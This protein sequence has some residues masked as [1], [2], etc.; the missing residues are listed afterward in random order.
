MPVPSN[1]NSFPQTG[2]PAVCSVVYS[3]AGGTLISAPGA[4]KHIHVL[5][6][7]SNN[8]VELRLGN[9]SGTIIAHIPGDADGLRFPGALDIGEDTALHCASSDDVT[10]FYYIHNVNLD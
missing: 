8:L 9:S 10:V 4:G 6:V 2:W 3:T 1:Y 5:G 7:I